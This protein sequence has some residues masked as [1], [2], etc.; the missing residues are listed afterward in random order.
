MTPAQRRSAASRKAARSR[1]RMKAARVS[2]T[3]A[4]SDNSPRNLAERILALTTPDVSSGWVAE[5]LRTNS[6]YV[7]AVWRR[8]GLDKRPMGINPPTCQQRQRRAAL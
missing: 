3:V 1:R 2:E 8:S 7:R 6:A 4:I 5:R